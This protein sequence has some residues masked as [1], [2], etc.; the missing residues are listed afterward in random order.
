MEQKERRTFRIVLIV[1]G[2]TI[3]AVILISRQVFS[4]ESAVSAY[5]ALCDALFVPGLLLLAGGLFGWLSADGSFDLM[6]YGA[7]RARRVFSH[8][9]GPRETYHDYKQ[10]RRQERNG[11][12]HYR[13]ALAI[14]AAFLALSGVFL[15]LYLGAAA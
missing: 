3:A 5:S 10:R 4:S 9:D 13:E 7:Q 6:G 15:L 11:R 14:G 12:K 1:V 8:E 2:L